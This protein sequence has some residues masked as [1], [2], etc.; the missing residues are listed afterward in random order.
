MAI[1]AGATLMARRPERAAKYVEDIQRSVS[2]MTGLIDNMLDLARG[3][4]G[5][6]LSL[7]RDDRESL[8]PT[9]NQVIDELRL[10]HPDCAIEAVFALDETVSCDRAR[11][12]QLL[13]NLFG[14][15]V[16]HGTP[17]GALR[18]VHCEVR[19]NAPHTATVPCCHNDRE[20]DRAIPRRVAADRR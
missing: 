2:R 8:E 1:S 20:T 16:T 15:A 3:R 5:E 10:S 9:L 17:D 12:A 19:A 4:L 11:I 14:N 13:S 6:G 18:C 7:K